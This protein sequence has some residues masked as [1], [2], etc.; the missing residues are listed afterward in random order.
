MAHVEH[1]QR[2]TSTDGARRAWMA[3]D[4]T[5]GALRAWTS[6]RPTDI[7]H[8][9]QTSPLMLRNDAVIVHGAQSAPTS[10]TTTSPRRLR[11][12]M[13]PSSCTALSPR[14]RRAQRPGRAADAQKDADIAHARQ[15]RRAQLSSGERSRAAA[16]AAR[17]L[18]DRLSME[19]VYIY[20]YP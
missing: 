11:S 16:S 20:I 4:E 6:H 19:L 14:R 3:D 12:E 2:M 7:V 13:T 9:D 10:S 15:Q 5:G 18:S 17:R 1:G 8:H